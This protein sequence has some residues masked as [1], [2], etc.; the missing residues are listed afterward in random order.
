MSAHRRPATRRGAPSWGLLGSVLVA[1]LVLG[2]VG[3]AL[4]M[5]YLGGLSPSQVLRWFVG[6]P[7][8]SVVVFTDDPRLPIHPTTFSVVSEVLLASSEQVAEVLSSSRTAFRPAQP[9]LHNH[10]A[11][12]LPA[13]IQAAHG[14]GGHLQP[15][16]RAYSFSVAS[17]G[18]VVVLDREAFAR[19]WR[20]SA[21]A[22][23]AA[24]APHCAVH[25]VIKALMSQLH[26]DHEGEGPLPTP[27]R[28]CA[29]SLATP[30][31]AVR[32]LFLSFPRDESVPGAFLCRVRDEL[33][34]LQRV[35]TSDTTWKSAP[36]GEGWTAEGECGVGEMCLNMTS[37]AVPASLSL[38]IDMVNPRAGVVIASV[39]ETGPLVHH[40]LLWRGGVAWGRET[41]EC[42]EAR[43]ESFEM[44][45]AMLDATVPGAFR[46]FS[47]IGYVLVSDRPQSTLRAAVHGL[48]CIQASWMDRLVLELDGREVDQVA[49]TIE[50]SGAAVL[51]E[52]SET[53][54]EWSPWALSK[55]TTPAVYRSGRSQRARAI[56]ISFPDRL[57]ALCRVS[58]PRHATASGT[59][60]VV[61]DERCPDCHALLSIV[62]EL[63]D[64][65]YRVSVVSVGRFHSTTTADVVELDLE[66]H[67]HI[68][69]SPDVPSMRQSYAVLRHVLSLEAE[70][71]VIVGR[72]TGGSTHSLQQYR[73]SG[74]GLL[75]TQMILVADRT[76][77]QVLRDSCVF[78][79]S[80]QQMTAVAFEEQVMK[81]AD[82]VLFSSA[83]Q[84]RRIVELGYS[85]PRNTG[86]VSEEVLVRTRT[87]SSA[88]LVVVETDTTAPCQIDD[89]AAAIS[90]IWASKEPQSVGG[91]VYYGG[92]H[93]IRR[94][95]ERLDPAVSPGYWFHE[96]KEAEFRVGT[97]W[98]I[99]Y[100]SSRE[101]AMGAAK[102]G[103]VLGP[104][105]LTVLPTVPRGLAMLMP[106][107]SAT[108]QR[109]S[110]YS[111]ATVVG[112]ASAA[113]DWVHHKRKHFHE[114]LGSVWLGRMPQLSTRPPLDVAA[115]GPLVTVCIP[116]YN[117]GEE[118]L[119]AVQSV[120]AS[121]YRDL[122]VL[123]VDDGSEARFETALQGVE[124]LLESRG[125]LIRRSH[126][127][128]TLAR[129]HCAHQAAGEFV[130]FF[131]S[132]DF[133]LPDTIARLVALIQRQ[134][135][136]V[137][138][139]W[140]E[141][142]Q[143][144]GE[145]RLEQ[146]VPTGGWATAGDVG[147]LATLV[148]VFGGAG[149]LHRKASLLRVGAFT[150]VPQG[151]A[152][153]D[154]NLFMKE[155]AAGQRIITLPSPL[156]FYRVDSPGSVFSN[157][158]DAFWSR[159]HALDAL[160]QPLTLSDRLL[161][162]YAVGRTELDVAGN[163]G[164]DHMT[165]V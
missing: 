139:G 111:P 50:P 114:S 40:V 77:M 143:D 74:L 103:V 55:S 104:P 149:A 4:P 81:T 106:A 112:L 62:P 88:E 52:L 44:P 59:A 71:A 160:L 34:Q 164:L 1:V 85:A 150:P 45:R 108:D 38:L 43:F 26:Y 36:C 53:P 121:T 86:V 54:G 70:P 137:V 153:Q 126:I 61:A 119:G 98:R 24:R 7:R 141:S 134:Q 79:R 148:D 80:A 117:R 124:R 83:K 66:R 42:V 19:I 28:E 60:L 65:G 51:F 76:T 116:T 147:P 72:V 158:M 75:Q 11:V 64:Q 73:E 163:S 130:Y 140:I 84:Q 93:F 96:E 37:A 27:P 57:S 18:G 17:S 144:G 165:E 101:R 30:Q 125:R 46:A 90:R 154:Y 159:Q 92:K 31:E 152:Y 8:F 2:L 67:R 142:F 97:A 63:Q 99:Q 157:R 23:I 127:G 156:Y 32:T 110:T 138:A 10:V 6:S 35:V 78:L 135:A 13:T 82:R 151:I 68:V 131:D 133:L 146:V 33:S 5:V 9:V 115:N 87:Q 47:E 49:L 91:V 122:E 89:L 48:G 25:A 162:E 12:V 69:M 113:L 155:R 100:F 58:V 109:A 39:C 95:L 3:V 29:D 129:N 41:A 14:L 16:K 107:A 161:V 136:D 102:D 120:L 22:A 145:T 128:G 118:L 105:S 20:D 123:V 132:D 94:F 21:L 15:V 56:R